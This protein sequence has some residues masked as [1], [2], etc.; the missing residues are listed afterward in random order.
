MIPNETSRFTVWISFSAAALLAKMSQQHRR[1]EAEF[2][3]DLIRKG[4]D[5]RA[6]RIAGVAERAERWPS[7]G[8]VV[9]E[10]VALRLA[11]A[12]LAG[13]WAPLTDAEAARL[14]LSG[15]WPGPQGMDGHLVQRHYLLPTP[16]VQCLRR[17]SWRV[18]QDALAELERRKLVGRF[19]DDLSEQQEGDRQR[20]GAA[21][22]SPGRIVR[23][24]L[25]RYGPV[26]AAPEDAE[27]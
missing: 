23:E 24:G 25:R 2:V 14:S 27:N 26:P 12:D 8:A 21:V 1:E 18:S 20:L 13:P 22:Y 4:A 6:A 9:A 10:A 17:A 5:K 7:M 16:L 11:E 3:A 15:A 19:A